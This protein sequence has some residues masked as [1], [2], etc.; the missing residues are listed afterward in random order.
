MM[1]NIARKVN[2]NIIV[3]SGFVEL[4][5]P[6]VEQEKW[7]DVDWYKYIEILKLNS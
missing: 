5:S 3:S 6:K 4:F 7:T 2:L 1:K